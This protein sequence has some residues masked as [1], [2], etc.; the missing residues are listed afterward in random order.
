ML[1]PLFLI[2]SEPTCIT[3]VIG[4]VHGTYDVLTNGSLIMTPF[5]DGFQ[6]IQEP[7]A[8]KSNFFEDYN[9]TELYTSWRIYLDA[10]TGGYKLHLFNF[11][12]S[13]VAPLF[14]VSSTPNMLP[15]RSLRNVT[16]AAVSNIKSA[17]KVT[18]SNAAS[19]ARGLQGAAVLV[20]ALVTGAL[21]FAA[22]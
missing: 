9:M 7:C 10:T 12:G 19:P 3:G 18:K 13:P 14:Q 4:W 5:G 8:A 2:G 22:L 21:A 20:G 15:T 16:G 11:D 17:V 1:I 6:Q